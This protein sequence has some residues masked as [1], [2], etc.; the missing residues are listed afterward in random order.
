MKYPHFLIYIVLLINTI[1]ASANEYF[2]TVLKNHEYIV[3]VKLVKGGAV[4]TDNT[5]TRI[6]GINYEAI[7]VE[8]LSGEDLQ[9]YDVITKDSLVNFSSSVP[10]SIN[11]E[12][13]VYLSKLNTANSRA[14]A[15]TFVPLTPEEREGDKQCRGQLNNLY[16]SFREIHPIHYQPSNGV[17]EGSLYIKFQDPWAVIPESLLFGYDRGQDKGAITWDDLKGYI[18][19]LHNGGS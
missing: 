7:A 2:Q 3:R 4:F 13:L 18:A 14:G 19:E 16:V 9:K 8:L 15:Y 1:T 12:Y 11:S 5:R 10:L 6:C 17:R